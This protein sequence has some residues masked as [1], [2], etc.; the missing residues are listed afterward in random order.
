[1]KDTFH[2]AKHR[3]F[4]KRNGSADSGSSNDARELLSLRMS[5]SLQR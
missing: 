3:L 5:G 4:E 1:M 2:V